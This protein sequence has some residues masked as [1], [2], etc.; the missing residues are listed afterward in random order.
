M[1]SQYQTVTFGM[2]GESNAYQLEY[3]YRL[4][5]SD[6]PSSTWGSPLLNWGSSDR[7]IEDGMKR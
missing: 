5:L 3:S 6:D 2:N 1:K 7:S 4:L